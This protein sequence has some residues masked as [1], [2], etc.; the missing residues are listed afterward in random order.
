[1]VKALWIIWVICELA[2]IA[3]LLRSVLPPLLR[4]VRKKPAPPKSRKENPLKAIQP[5]YLVTM[6]AILVLAGVIA[7]IMSLSADY[8]LSL[9]DESVA[10]W[11][12]LIVF[13]YELCFVAVIGVLNRKW[14]SSPAPWYA[15]TAVAFAMTVGLLLIIC[16]PAEDKFLKVVTY[17][18][19]FLNFAIPV[20]IAVLYAFYRAFIKKK[21][22]YSKIKKQRRRNKI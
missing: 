7:L 3:L 17:T 5:I 14:F 18:F 22:D 9:V 6:A 15:L 10:G 11:I 12:V 20:Y 21:I 2:F 1:M 19:S 8:F 4:R 13:L 16:V